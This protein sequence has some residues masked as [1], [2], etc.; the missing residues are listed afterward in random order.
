MA[1]GAGKVGVGPTVGWGV[2]VGSGLAVGPA[3]VGDAQDVSKNRII[4][5]V[6]FRRTA[7]LHRINGEYFTLKKTE[8][9]RGVSANL[10][11]GK[12]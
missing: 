8:T 9:P 7:I 4:R 12:C 10:G 6:S 11:E 5:K 3:A 1:N 2:S